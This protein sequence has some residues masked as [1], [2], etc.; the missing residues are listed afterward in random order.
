MTL[1]I[2]A[3]VD[4]SP[5]AA[6][7]D[8]DDL[9]PVWR[10]IVTESRARANDIHL[11][12]SFAFAERLCDAYPEA[13]ALVVRVAILLHDTG[14]ARVD[15]DRIIS[16]GFSGDWRRADVRYEHERHG[17]DIARTVLPPL[18]YD[19]DFIQ[20]VVDIIDGHDTRPES[21]SLEDSLVRDAD[22]LWR[23]TPAGIALASG[24]FGLTPAEY[25][26][27]LRSE[28][29]PELLTDAAVQ[30]AET[31]LA[32]SEVLLKTEQLA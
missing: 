12:I 17:C 4:L 32:R 26:R 13:D 10:S 6:D 1:P 29:I 24:W 31:E 3:P 7:V 8:R 9:D 16:E 21:H 23:F 5:I 27:R 30:M 11:P 20:R 25:T 22:R 28:I 19:A 18:G 15:E 14:W 2:A